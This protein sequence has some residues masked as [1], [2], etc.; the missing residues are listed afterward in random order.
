MKKRIAKKMMR[1]FCGI[2]YSKWERQ[3]GNFWYRKANKYTDYGLRF[4]GDRQK[5][6]KFSGLYISGAIRR[7]NIELINKVDGIQ[8]EILDEIRMEKMKSDMPP[9]KYLKEEYHGS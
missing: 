4:K 9:F 3:V 7:Y 1:H 5:F 6:L 2:D 8:C